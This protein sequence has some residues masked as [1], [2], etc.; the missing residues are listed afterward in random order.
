MSD[1]YVLPKPYVLYD[2]SCKMCVTATDQLRDLDTDGVIEWRDMHDEAMH[3]KFPNL[4][5]TRV[6]DEIHLIHRDGRVRTGS[7]AVRDISELIGGEVGKAAARALDLP[8]VKDASDLI[9]RIVSENRH[10]IMG[11]N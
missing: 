4:D 3:R 10:K 1:H 9:Y 2:G 11:K 7:R 8:G 6:K 5:W